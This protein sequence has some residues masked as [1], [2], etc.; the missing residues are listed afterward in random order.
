[1]GLHSHYIRILTAWNITYLESSLQSSLQNQ[2]K[3]EANRKQLEVGGIL[4]E[5]TYFKFADEVIFAKG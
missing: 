5:L 3:R 4:S 2:T 1:V